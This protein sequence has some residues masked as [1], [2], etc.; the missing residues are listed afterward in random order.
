MTTFT[1]KQVRDLIDRMA[2]EHGISEIDMACTVIAIL[3][4][5]LEVLG[6]VEEAEIQGCVPPPPPKA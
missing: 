5:R 1:P 4:A 6:Y 2:R 3:R